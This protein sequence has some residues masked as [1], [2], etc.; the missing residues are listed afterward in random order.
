MSKDNP[1]YSKVRN[2]TILYSAWRKVYEN[3]IISKSLETRNQVKEF[4]A[5]ALREINKIADRLY[6]NKFSFAPAIGIPQKRTG[7]K[8]PR[9]IVKSPIPNRIVQRS[10]LD[11]LQDEPAIHQYVF[12]QRSFGGIETRG[13][14]SAVKAAY[15][16]MQNGAAW[17][18]RSD[19]EGFFTQIPREKVLQIISD[20]IPDP[21]FN[22]L[23]TSA[24]TTELE[25]LDELGKN[26][27][28]FPIYD[29]GVAQGCCLSPL[30]G[31]I[32]LHDFDVKMNEGS[33]LCLRYID[34]F[35]ILGS[36]ERVV[37]QAFKK[38]IRLLNEHG[39]KAY[40][41]LVNKDKAEIGKT[42]KGF[43]F[44]GCNIHPGLIRPAK[45]S[46]NKLL[47][48]IKSIF[49]ES[50][51]LISN[52]ITL[53]KK[54]KTFIETLD[55]ASNIIR[56]WGNQYSFCNDVAITSALDEEI[57]KLLQEYIRYYENAKK[58]LR[59]D[60][61]KNFRRLIGVHLLSDSKYDPIIK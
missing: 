24:V 32:L 39:L 41:P 42:G 43:E 56:G 11:V 60:H 51:Q 29:I 5:V 4:S 48:N 61:N 45:K 14:T 10:I 3:G 59:Q 2:T 1:Y 22:K 16:A 20:K 57:D 21:L 44:L 13:V 55:S 58:M 34:D 26:A 12:V 36:N 28:L 46:R 27:E 15:D 52:P 47:I 7:K 37:M 40:D 54:R 19:I 18:I 6:R 17:Y 9:P 50:I 53:Y 31:N 8:K 49:K 38:A 33:F 25:N 23:L 30:I 35:L